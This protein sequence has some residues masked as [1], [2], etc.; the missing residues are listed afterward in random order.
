MP[1]DKLIKS[2]PVSIHKHYSYTNGYECLGYYLQF[3]TFINGHYIN[4]TFKKRVIDDSFNEQSFIYDCSKK[5]CTYVSTFINAI[6]NMNGGI[7]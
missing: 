5:W 2:V 7:N 3:S 4:K 6:N 1:K